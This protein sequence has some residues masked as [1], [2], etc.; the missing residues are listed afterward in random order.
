MVM[1]IAMSLSSSHEQ[2]SS[3]QPMVNPAVAMPLPLLRG[4]CQTYHRCWAYCRCCTG[5]VLMLLQLLRLPPPLRCHMPL[6]VAHTHS[7]GK[8]QQLCRSCCACHHCAILIPATAA[9]GHSLPSCC[10]H[11]AMT[12]APETAKAYL[13]LSC[14][15]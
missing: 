13:H 6:T 1:L 11:C 4:C 9:A 7:A 8:L 2:Q 12:A 3:N 5:L 14:G 10:H 15:F